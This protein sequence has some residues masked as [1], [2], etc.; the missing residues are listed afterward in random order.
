[1]DQAADIALPDRQSARQIQLTHWLLGLNDL[2]KSARNAGSYGLPG[3]RRSRHSPSCFTQLL[4]FIDHRA[5]TSVKMLVSPKD[6]PKGPPQP[7][8]QGLCRDMLHRVLLAHGKAGQHRPPQTD[9]DQLLDG[10]DASEFH[11]GFRGISRPREPTVDYAARVSTAFIEKQ[12]LLAEKFRRDGLAGRPVLRGENRHE[13]IIIDFPDVERTAARRK[14]DQCKI[15][16]IAL[17]AFQNVG[18]VP[19]LDGDLQPRHALSQPS[20][21]RRKQIDAGGGSSPDPHPAQSAIPVGSYG[22]QGVCH[23]LPNASG[24]DEQ[25]SSGEC[26][27][28]S[29]SNSLDELDAQMPLKLPNLKAHCRLGDAQALRGGR[30]AAEFYDIGERLKLIEADA[31]HQSFSYP[32]HN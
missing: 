19:G 9:S 6:H 10:L 8:R 30:E 7:G 4:E 3:E 23:L 15:Q 27:L 29:P 12:R 2:I 13:F 22:F 14:R 17:Q 1:M 31:F 32:L 28:G 21:R 25:V 16:S 20:K 11:H 18:R 24:V 26:R 5:K